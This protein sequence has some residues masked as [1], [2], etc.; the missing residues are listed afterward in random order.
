MVLPKSLLGL[1]AVA[2][3][4]YG[5]AIDETMPD[6][7]VAEDLISSAGVGIPDFAQKLIDNG[8]ALKALNT[9]ALLNSYRYMKGG[10]NILNV[11]VRQEWYVS[12]S[13]RSSPLIDNGRRDTNK[14]IVHR[15][16]L[17]ASQRKQYISAVKCMQNKPSLLPDVPGSYSLYDDFTAVHL[18]LTMLIH[19][20]GNFPTWHRYMMHTYEQELN[21][22]GYKGNLPYWEW[23]L[24]VNDLR[25]SPVFDGSDTSLG[26]DGEFLNEP[27]LIITPAPGTVP[28]EP[29]YMPP[30][31]GGG[32]IK[33][34]P[35]KGLKMRLGP[36]SMPIPGSTDFI[37][38]ED[39]M[40]DNPRCVSRDL[41]NHIAKTYTSFRNSTMLLLKNKNIEWFQ[42][43]LVS[44]T[45]TPNP[46][47][48]PPM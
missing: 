40:Q 15:R 29:I 10:C 46:Y 43:Q 22:C 14:T 23:G 20:T 38:V 12:H 28:G 3:T 1:L 47:P 31:T 34:G 18:N 36:S 6:I 39:P 19:N 4:A 5:A 13:L 17:S 37:A 2:S 45:P 9:I 25:K 11:K 35:F 33:S 21:K 30:G 24:D 8:A 7:L 44:H 27:G 26:S 16:T 41:N 48:P 32:C 42:G